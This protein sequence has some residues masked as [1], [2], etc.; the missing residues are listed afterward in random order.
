MN[1]QIIKTWLILAYPLLHNYLA[2]CDILAFIN[3]NVDFLVKKFNSVTKVKPLGN[4]SGYKSKE[5][6]FG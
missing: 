6:E 1:Q 3:I 2:I 4:V 5:C